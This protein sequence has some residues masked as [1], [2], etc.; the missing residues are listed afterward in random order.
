MVRALC[1]SE[2]AMKPDIFS[3]HL[4]SVLVIF[5]LECQTHILSAS[6]GVI[7]SLFSQRESLIL[8]IKMKDNE[9]TGNKTERF[10]INTV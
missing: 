7:F 10:Q 5:P 4:V 9:N 8:E 3:F 2:G 6:V 1:S